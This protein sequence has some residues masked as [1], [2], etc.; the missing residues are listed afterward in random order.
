[1]PADAIVA[2]G[3]GVPASS[4][5]MPV[6]PSEAAQPEYHGR[7]GRI[8]RIVL[9]NSLLGL[10]TL[11]LYRFWGHTRLRRYLWSAVRIWGDP[12][13]YTGRALELFV[14]FLIALVV[15]IPIGVGYA[16]LDLIAA[17]WSPFAHLAAKMAYYLFFYFL[18][19]V[20]IFRARRYRLSRTSWRQIRAGQSG[21]SL[22]FGL[23]WLGYG[24]LT[25]VTL[26]L[27]APVKSV[28]TAHYLATNSWFGDRRFEFDARAGDMF[29]KWLACWLLFIPTLGFSSLWFSA[30]RMRYF[31][32]R[33][34]FGPLR[35]SLRINFED[36]FWIYFPYMVIVLGL[37]GG[38][39]FAFGNTMSGLSALHPGSHVDPAAVLHSLIAPGIGYIVLLF[40]IVPVLSATMITHR[41]LGLCS[42]R[43]TIIGTPDFAAVRQSVQTA[44]GTGEGL[45][46]ALDVGAAF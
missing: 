43:L 14:G 35:F 3:V 38:L 12:V 28:R 32:E 2:A 13:V 22:R 29:R 46:D 8:A 7:A 9:G 40:V 20:A 25:L 36:L 41:S 19:G 34:G 37:F 44:P 45:A 33:T 21:S 39:G 11:G 24:L 18:I 27:A 30:Y 42:D 16:V 23:L 26:G 31:A 4:T 6:P 10:I 15:L 1:M 17:G 5:T